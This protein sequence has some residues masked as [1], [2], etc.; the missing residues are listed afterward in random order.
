MIS[1]RA[2]TAAPVRHFRS[3]PHLCKKRKIAVPDSNPSKQVTGG[4][5]KA[6]RTSEKADVSADE[7]P[8]PLDFSALHEAFVPID[9][10]FKSQLQ[11]LIHGGRFNPD[12][13]G[14]LPV[15]TKSAEGEAQTFPLRELAQV[16][17]RG[18]THVSLL[19]ND[20]E[21]AKA[22]MSAV[23]NAPQ[24]NQQP[25]RS[26]ENELELVMRVEMDRK[27]EVVKRIKELGQQ[28]RDRVRQARG[29]HEKL[30]K[31]WKKK[32]VVL[33]DDLR[34]AEKELQKVQDKK[35]KEIEGEEAQA[36]KQ[37]QR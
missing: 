4:R 14:A 24:F 21:Y 32:G 6:D 16:V 1:S 37:L 18:R 2:T 30:L 19:L 34:K 29:K 15:S 28:W 31:D 13:L 22:V 23:Q 17:P 33:P 35:M 20:A 8:D 12:V 27:D 3:S 36:V 10:N 26:E 25:Q 7:Q 5:Q 9:S 11:S